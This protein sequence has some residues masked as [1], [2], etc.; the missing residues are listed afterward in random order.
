M[1]H[2]GAAHGAHRRHK[3]HGGR[4]FRVNSIS[5]KDTDHSLVVAGHLSHAAVA[6]AHRRRRRRR[7]RSNSARRRVRVNRA[8]STSRYLPL[9]TI[10]GSLTTN[11]FRVLSSRAGSL[12]RA[13]HSGHGVVTIRARYQGTSGRA[14]RAYRRATSRHSRRRA[15]HVVRLGTINGRRLTRRHNKVYTSHLRATTTRHG[16][17]RRASHRVRQHNRSRHGTTDRRGALSVRK[18]DTHF[19][20]H[21]GGTRRRGRTGNARYVQLLHKGR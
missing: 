13:G 17:S 12:A 1:L 14:R 5:T 20:C 7:N 4:R 18:G 21:G 15:R 6:K 3:G 10:H 8:I 16:L 11:R 9:L 2:R 19:A